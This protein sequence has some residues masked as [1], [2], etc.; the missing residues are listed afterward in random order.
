MSI[1]VD[2]MYKSPIGKFGRMKMSHMVADT[3]KELVDM[4]AKIGVARK[5]IQDEGTFK[6]HFDICMSKRE[7]AIKHGA[8]AIMF[9][10]LGLIMYKRLKKIHRKED[11]E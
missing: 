4:A 2:D 3:T 8:K 1:Y 9:H 5:W 11:E 7:L 6:E 10:D